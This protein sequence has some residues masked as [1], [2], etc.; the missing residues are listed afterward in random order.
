MLFGVDFV[1][2]FWVDGFGFRYFNEL[3][4][5]KY[6]EIFGLVSGLVQFIGDQYVKVYIEGVIQ[7]M[8]IMNS[9]LVEGDEYWM[10]DFLSD[11]SLSYLDQV[12]CMQI[13]LFGYQFMF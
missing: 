13:N 1:V 10:Y 7:K 3:C 9:G 5:M 12:M 6:S 8:R 2:N 4:Q 11:F